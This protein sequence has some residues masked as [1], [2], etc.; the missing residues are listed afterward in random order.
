MNSGITLTRPAESAD[1]P[2][3]SE[4][5]Y[6]RMTLLMQTNPR[7]RLLPDAR[8]RWE[9]AAQRWLHDDTMIFLAGLADAEVAGGIVGKIEPNAPGL[10]PEQYARLVDFVI[11]VHTIHQQQGIGRVLLNAFREQVRR[12]GITRLSVQVMDGMAVEQAFWHGMGAKSY[13]ELVWIDV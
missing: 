8:A 3:L 5:W 11:D 6:D 1:I 7:I 9:V 12:A 2:I 4:Y 13:A 10:I